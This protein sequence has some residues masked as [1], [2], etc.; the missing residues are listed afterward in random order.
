M[1]KISIFFMS[2]ICILMVGCGNKPYTKEVN[3][4]RIT[5]SNVEKDIT[6]EL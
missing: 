4:Y 1:K 5:H 6:F 2:L 3:T